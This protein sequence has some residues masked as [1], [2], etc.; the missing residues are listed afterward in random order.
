MALI[1]PLIHFSG[2]LGLMDSPNERKVHLGA[3]PRVGGIGMVIGVLLPI[4]LWVPLERDV[5]SLLIGIGILLVFGILDDRG[6]LDY[7][8]KFL[9][10][11]IAVLVVVFYGDVLIRV[12]PFAGL[13]PVS[14][15][16][17]IPLTIVVLV[18]VTNAINLAD[19]LDGLA[20]GTVL[21]SLAGTGFIAYLADGM[22]LLIIIIAV[23]GAIT[24]FLRFNTYPARIFMGDAGSQFLGFTIGVLLVLLTQ[25]INPA[26]NPAIP[27]LLIGLP[28]FD[29]MFVVF[30]RIYHGHSPFSP[31]KN[32]VHHQLLALRFDHY[33]A[34]II[35]YL[36]QAVFVVSGVLFRYQSDIFVTFLWISMN[37]FLAV[38]LVYSGRFHWYAHAA[39]KKSVLASLVEGKARHFLGKLALG[40]ILSGVLVLLFVGPLVVSRVESDLGIA[41]CILFLFLLLR[42]VL[43]TRLWFISLRLILYVT[44]AFVVYLLNEYPPTIWQ[45]TDTQVYTYFGAITVAIVIGAKSLDADTFQV[46]PTDILIIM[47]VVAV[48]LLPKAQISDKTVVLLFIKFVVIF[49]AVEILIRK[50]SFRWN[51]LTAVSIWALGIIGLRGVFNL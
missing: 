46:T 2:K 29:T 30:K 4:I 40:T 43:D 6:D 41:A 39:E 9:G 38:T 5:V 16:L 17:S 44:A 27:L 49:Y 3:I 50:I 25:E 7:R 14:P 32:H 19:G 20:A 22:D 15:W 35:I 21:L 12:V 10:Q 48:A 42:L 8:I 24:G 36:V 1:P 31:D 51:V 33:E 47:L 11:L 37:I 13:D 18:A 28:V 34:V 23:M 26:L 45:L